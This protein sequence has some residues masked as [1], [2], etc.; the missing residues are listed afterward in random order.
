MF[1]L[2]CHFSYAEQWVGLFTASVSQL[3]LARGGTSRDGGNFENES[4]NP[5]EP[6]RVS[7]LLIVALCCSKFKKR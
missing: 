5:E 3:I 4:A 1:C 2:A 6:E 7:L